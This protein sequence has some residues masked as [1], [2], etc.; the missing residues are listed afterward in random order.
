MAK[1]NA[2]K[3]AS[4][5][6]K[7]GT[8][9]FHPIEKTTIPGEIIDQILS[10]ILT[11]KLKA[12]EKLPPERQL[13]ESFNVGRSSVR[14]ALKALETLG[15]IRRDIRG[16]TVCE[17]WENRYPGLSLTA[18]DASLAQ[19]LESARI[20]GIEVAGLAAERAKP[21]HIR[22][23][24]RRLRESEDTQDA[25]AIHLSY[26]RALVAAAQN[27]VLSQMYNML[28]ALV[29]QSRQLVAAVQGMAE[30]KRKTFIKDI[31]DGHRKILKAVESHNPAA[32]R[33]W[34][35]EHFDCMENMA[36]GR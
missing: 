22:K 18:V 6:K 20:V 8:L 2:A 3:S 21:E 1:T 5:E 27:P 16:T 30:P 36:L 28:I 29:S 14:E 13:C 34:M 19:S 35:K 10:M 23:L 24:A 9:H 32:A 7:A 26:H 15:I 4:S 12:E 17:P 33:K 31:F 25:A 11:G